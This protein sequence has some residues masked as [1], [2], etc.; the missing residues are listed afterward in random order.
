M[1]GA[2]GKPSDKRLQFSVSSIWPP[3][4]VVSRDPASLAVSQSIF[5]RCFNFS[6]SLPKSNDDLPTSADAKEV[7]L[8]EDSYLSNRETAVEIQSELVSLPETAGTFEVFDYVPPGL[9]RYAECDPAV[10]SC[11]FVAEL[12][13]VAVESELAD[14]SEY[15]GLAAP[16]DRR[17]EPADA[18]CE[19]AQ[20]RDAFPPPPLY[21]PFDVARHAVTS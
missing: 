13:Q 7:S 17:Q 21:V 18:S 11:P 5:K 12:A 20:R 4:G 14:A 1:R 8:N 15:S 3:A 6:S 10:M 19:T 2:D 16:A 9:A